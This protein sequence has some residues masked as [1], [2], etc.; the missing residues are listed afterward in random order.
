MTKK[1]NNKKLWTKEETALF[2]QIFHL[3]T[4]AELAEIFNCEKEKINNK[5][6]TENLSS[7]RETDIPEGKKKCSTCQEIFDLDF[8]D[9]NR[10]NKDGKASECKSCSRMR[11]SLAHRKKKYEQEQKELEEK[12]TAYIKKFE[13]K[14]ITCKHHG[15]QTIDDYRLFINTNGNYSRKCKKCE[16][17][18]LKKRK[19]KQLKEKGYA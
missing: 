14:T 2:R 4:T 18:A 7:K 5:A 8:F 10:Y 6:I 1:T 9:N 17:I 16:Y 15:E 3:Y 19:E 12:R 13:G 11:K